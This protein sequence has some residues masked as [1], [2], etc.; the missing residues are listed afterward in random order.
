MLRDFLNQLLLRILRIKFGQE[1]E[2]DWL[3][4]RNIV[5]QHLQNR[6]AVDKQAMFSLMPS[7]KKLFQGVYKYF[8]PSKFITF[9]K[10]CV[11]L[12]FEALTRPSITRG[13]TSNG[14]SVPS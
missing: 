14:I 9:A 4:L 11:I 8:F 13:N 12:H 6:R 7:S 2:G 1:V 10:G 3:F 5:I